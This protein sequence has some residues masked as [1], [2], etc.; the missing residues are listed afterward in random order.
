MEV[1]KQAYQHPLLTTTDLD[2][3]FAA[4]ERVDLSKGDYILEKGQTLQTYAIL[5]EGLI[6]SFLYDYEGNEMTTGFIS[7][8]EV[9]IET[10]SFFQRIPTQ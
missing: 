4:H 6:R 3:I 1:L 7:K 2:L 9:V 5:E 8:G 10:A